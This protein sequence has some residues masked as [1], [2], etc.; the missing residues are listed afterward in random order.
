MA[1]FRFFENLTMSKLIIGSRGSKLALWQSNWVKN[2]L[3][4]SHHGLRVE[5]EI[6]TTTGDQLADASLTQIGGKGVFTKELEDALLEGR[7]QLAVHSLKD[8]PTVLPDGLHI[9]A[10]SER[11]DVR[12]ALILNDKLK[13]DVHS[14]KDL[15]QGARI[16]TSSQRRR[17]QLLHLRPDLQIF[18]LRGNVDTRL[19]KL[20]EGQYDAIILA[21]AGLIRLGLSFRIALRIDISEMLPAV[22]QAAL[23]IESRIDDAVTNHFLE[24]LNHQPTK[25]AVDAE[26]ALLRTL[27]GGCSVPVAAFA[28]IR[29]D[30]NTGKKSPRLILDA[31][32]ADPIGTILIRRQAKGPIS[33]ADDMGQELAKSLLSAGAGDILKNIENAPPFHKPVPPPEV[34]KTKAKAMAAPIAP[35]PAPETS[36]KNTVT[37]PTALPSLKGKKIISTR[38]A[39]QGGELIK[40]LTDI[41]AEVI[42]CPT[43]EISEPISWDDLDKSLKH[44]SWY[45]TITFTS[46]NGVEYFLNRLDE[47]G[48][49]RAELLPIRICA[50]GKKTEELLKK[51]MIQVDLMPEEFTAENLAEEFIKRYGVRERLRGSRMLLPTSQIAGDTIK[52]SLERIGVYVEL[53]EAYQTIMPDVSREELEETLSKAKADYIIF[54]SP[55]TIINLAGLLLTDNLKQFLGD[56]RVACIGPIT[57]EIATQFGL[58]VSVQPD[59]HTADALVQGIIRNS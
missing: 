27:G 55:S 13:S 42:S 8:L 54:T 48:H 29:K 21:S 11:E 58:E 38:S 22:G 6:I 49:S 52:T 16:G 3:E 31:V 36:K 33:R 47:L 40:Q 44:L 10:V 50:V 12:D 37:T 17:S 4:K 1:R 14:I 9:A 53:V 30:R 57:A 45:D 43:I 15:P 20:D 39:K 18:E 2:K 28:C 24:C 34:K 41:G 5:I 32:V 26:R 51:E 46:A 59:E 7:I 25:F 19:K 23:G 56:T 35:A